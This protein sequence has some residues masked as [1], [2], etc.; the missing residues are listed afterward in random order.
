MWDN[1]S[2]F[3]G[4]RAE[5]KVQ[6]KAIFS[7]SRAVQ[8]LI[9]IGRIELMALNGTDYIMEDGERFSL[10]Y[11]DR[12]SQQL[13]SIEKQFKDVK[14]EIGILIH[15][16]A[17]SGTSPDSTVR[18]YFDIIKKQSAQMEFLSYKLVYQ[19]GKMEQKDPSS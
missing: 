13:E 19:L 15:H 9:A 14:K 6:I 8:N 5:L 10:V 18:D 2:G 17:I 4:T 12:Y 7:Q 3:Y 16:D 1:W 11:L